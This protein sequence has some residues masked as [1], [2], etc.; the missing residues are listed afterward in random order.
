MLLISDSKIAD[1]NAGKAIFNAIDY[2]LKYLNENFSECEIIGLHGGYFF[3]MIVL[4]PSKYNLIG[5]KNHGIGFNGFSFIYLINLFICIVLKVPQYLFPV[6]GSGIPMFV[7]LLVSM[8]FPRKKWWFKYANNWN[9]N[10]ESLF[11][12]KS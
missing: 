8:L 1:T 6:R 9:S 3:D 2:E 4:N 7:S 12:D 10:G 5:L 11:L